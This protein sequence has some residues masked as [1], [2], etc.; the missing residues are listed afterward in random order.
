MWA[1][2]WDLDPHPLKDPLN[3]LCLRE[4]SENGLQKGLS[5]P[6][7]GYMCHGNVWPQLV[8]LL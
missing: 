6:F 7:F 1:G 3:L 4:T 2:K 8:I 5:A